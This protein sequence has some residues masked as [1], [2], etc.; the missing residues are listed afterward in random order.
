MSRVARF[1]LSILIILPGAFLLALLNNNES[2]FT[3]TLIAC[4]LWWIW[5]RQ[6]EEPAETAHPVW[7]TPETHELPDLATLHDELRT[8]R[9]EV[10][11]LREEVII[12]KYR[13]GKQTHGRPLSTLS[14]TAP[15]QPSAALKV[16]AGTAAGIWL[17]AFASAL[18]VARLVLQ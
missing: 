2:F 11:E 6:S 7:H 18:G 8:L 13:L 1:L 4:I 16:W 12:L 10:Q 17:L 15:R 3:L 14:A 5:P 9:A